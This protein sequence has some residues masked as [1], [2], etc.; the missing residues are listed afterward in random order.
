MSLW[1]YMSAAGACRLSHNRKSS[2]SRSS[3]S[4]TVTAV[5]VCSDAIA[6]IPEPPGTEERKNS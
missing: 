6:R 2:T 5:V 3:C 1:R 4:F